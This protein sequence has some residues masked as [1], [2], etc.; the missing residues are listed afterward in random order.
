MEPNEPFEQYFHQLGDVICLMSMKI[1]TFKMEVS[2]EM[3][4]IQDL[5]TEQ[6][7]RD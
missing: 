2:T 3:I 7:L 5:F 6:N 1:W 4:Q